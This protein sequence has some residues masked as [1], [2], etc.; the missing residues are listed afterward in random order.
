MTVDAFYSDD[1]ITIYCSDARDILP[2][3]TNV[4]C[5]VS[6][7]PYNAGIDYDEY[8]DDWDWPTYWA[9]GADLAAGLHACTIPGARVWWN[10][11]VSVPLDPDPASSDRRR[12][13]LAHD[14][15]ATLQ[16]AGFEWRDTVSWPSQRGS[17]TAW[18]SYQ[19]PTAPNLRGD[20]EAIQ[21]MF[22]DHWERE[23][24]PGFEGF[25]DHEGGW[26]K[27]CSTVWADITPE[28]RTPGGHPVPFPVAL[29]TRCIRLSTWPGETVL[30]PYMGSGTT[31]LAARNLG[32]KAIGV[33]VS[34]AY[35]ARAVSRL[36]QGALDFGGAA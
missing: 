5:V 13:P 30:D 17:G 25:E 1:D 36:S 14:W 35:C 33:E 9:T 34:E 29:P 6:S 19:R 4:A 11:A 31:L 16:A 2:T 22:R 8:A 23:A 28:H 21:V 15:T 26:P 7:P 3:L 24:P 20:Y 27:M 32:R 10:T 12:V 18:G